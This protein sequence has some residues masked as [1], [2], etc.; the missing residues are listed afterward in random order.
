LG[1]FCINGV[2]I[3]LALRRRKNNCRYGNPFA[4]IV[5]PRVEFSY[6]PNLLFIKT[7][8]LWE[9]LSWKAGANLVQ[10]EAMSKFRLKLLCKNIA[11]ILR[12]T[13]RKISI[14]TEIPDFNKAPL[15]R[16]KLG[17]VL[18]WIP[19]EDEEI[20]LND[21]GIVIGRFYGY[22]PE[23]GC[24]LWCYL[25]LLD[26]DSPSARWCAVDTAWEDDLERLDHE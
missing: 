25:I 13:A 3:L 9:F 5:C 18:R 21:W 24:W 2:A 26:P 16:F 8:D 14:S 20:A 1:F 19:L 15:P 23:R 17:T 4:L 7:R 6:F 11:D 12:L 10:K 22:A